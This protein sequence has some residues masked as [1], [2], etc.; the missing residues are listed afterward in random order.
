MSTEITQLA[1]QLLFGDRLEDKLCRPSKV[2]DCHPER[3]SAAP[4]LPGRPNSAAWTKSK[5]PFPKE[6]ALGDDFERG[7]ALL[8]FANHELLAIELMALCLLRFP[9]APSPFR[10]GLLNTIFEE[11]DHFLRY[12]SRASELGVGLEDVGVNRF[13]WDC[14]SDMN[15]P[16]D[17]VV[18][19][20]MTFEQANLDHCIHYKALFERVGD[21]KSAEIMASIYADEIRHLRQGIRWFRHWKDPSVTDF[22]AHEGHLKLP[23]SMARAK[24]RTYDVNGR[25][26][27]GLTPD[28]VEQ[29]QVTSVSKGRLPNVL[30][31]WPN[32]ETYIAH[33]SQQPPM[34]AL[35]LAKECDLL[36]ILQARH[37]DILLVHKKPASHFLKPL[38]Q[39]GLTLPQFVEWDGTHWPDQLSERRIQSV[40]P[41][42]WCPV[43]S[44]TVPRKHR[45]W[46]ESYR[47]LHSKKWSTKMLKEWADDGPPSWCSQPDLVG[48]VCCSLEEIIQARSQCQTD[49]M[50][51]KSEFGTAGRQTIRLSKGP[52]SVSHR[53]WINRQLRTQCIVAEPWL[54]RVMDLSVQLSVSKNGNIALLGWNRFWTTANGQYRGHWL[55]SIHRHLPERF[56]R[57]M[58]KVGG[59]KGLN[60]IIN[61]VVQRVGKSLADNGYFGTAGID[62]LI[63]LRNGKFTFR[64]IV[65]V[66]PRYTMGQ[67]A[68]EAQ[69]ICRNPDALFL[70]VSH[71]DAEVLERKFPATGSGGLES[72]TLK[73]TN[74]RGP[75]CAILAVGDAAVYL[76][77][78]EK[79]D[80]SIKDASFD[81]GV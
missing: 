20:A 33:P 73:L 38:Q 63:H 50:V 45:R 6:S 5:S 35:N 29:L 47:V 67:M 57:W 81:L 44:G 34:K 59:S 27:A 2:T 75:H 28:Y 11:Q 14:L 25:I 72:G 77:E 52:L 78:R 37:G 43:I 79:L 51:L 54:N 31:F 56:R 26:A 74:G 49:W 9:D 10:K 53:N 41:W 71:Q 30:V 3:L 76:L 65:E 70:W 19:M 16:F 42:G 40:Q 46:Q 18:G 24:G 64:P 55:G 21:S 36:P 61:Q 58:Y 62:M 4:A 15:D 32:V 39:C 80:A 13:F 1:E 60:L 48:K 66:N 8:F 12:Y 69:K 7:R 22:T 23:L 68:I 17:F